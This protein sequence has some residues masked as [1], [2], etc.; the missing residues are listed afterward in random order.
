ML[1]PL[2]ILRW[3][4]LGRL[5][6]AVAIFIAAVTNWRDADAGDTLV[7]A[8]ALFG[9]I[10]FTAGSF[11]RSSQLRRTPSRGFFLA[12]TMADV[13]LV[14]AIIHLT[15]GGT[16]QLAA[17]YILVITAASVLLPVAWALGIAAFANGLYLTLLI[18][19]HRSTVSWGVALQLGVFAAVALGIALLSRRLREASAGKEQLEA[20]LALAKLQAD[21]ILR[22]IGSGILTVDDV[23][24]LLYVNPTAG[25]LL[26]L[27]ADAA[28]G[29]PM[30]E[31]LETIAP[32]LLRAMERTMRDRVRINRGEASILRDGRSIAI[33]LTT[34]TIDSGRE[35]S[36]VSATAIFQDITDN[37][38]ME[39]LRL[40]AERLEAV[41][42]LSASLAHEIKNP[43]ASIRSAVEQLA[44]SPKSNDDERVLAKLIVRESD[45]LSRLLS[46]FLDFAR[47]RVTRLGPVDLTAVAR[48]AASLAAAH[49]D[50]RSDVE[51]QCVVPAEPMIVEGDEDLLHRVAFNIALNAVQASPTHGA[52][53]IEV[54]PVALDQVP[55]GAPFERDAVAL[56]I[57]D[58]GPGIRDDIRDRIF[59]PFFTTKP[60][61]TGLGLPIVHRAIDALRGVVLVESAATGTA[62][63][64]LLPHASH[65]NG[66][67][68]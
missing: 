46:E 63:T 37:K 8:L 18:T 25:R 32:G 48:S 56:R 44:S 55:R 42:E 35:P 51:V 3:I 47:V 52:V 13:L 22:N 7:A 61:G 30:S 31:M 39:A 16:S 26:G 68:T 12:Q 19:L 24:R 43:L 33:G 5:S 36:G 53:R 62:F 67:A 65:D 64:V 41:T 29:R 38:R 4:Y 21:D 54:A 50:C 60:G 34:M 40:R 57:V 45:R 59:D 58:S 49:P 28:V 66:D 23:G 1:H 27:D 9:T 10:A 6:V 15:G 11:A 2:R 20:Q 14:T 17:L